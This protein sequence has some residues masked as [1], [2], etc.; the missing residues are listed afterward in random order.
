MQYSAP[1]YQDYH[2]NCKIAAGHP[3]HLEPPSACEDVD[4]KTCEG[5]RLTRDWCNRTYQAQHGIVTRTES[6]GKSV[7]SF[8]WVL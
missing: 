3:N 5:F 8:L 2:D 7:S 1:R 6:D 4:C